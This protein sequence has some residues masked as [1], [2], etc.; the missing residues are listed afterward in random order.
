MVAN[1]TWK[2]DPMKQQEKQEKQEKVQE[3]DIG[4]FLQ[5]VG[6]RLRS[7]TYRKEV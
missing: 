4:V 5:F 7:M 1:Y 3:K 2:P 6:W